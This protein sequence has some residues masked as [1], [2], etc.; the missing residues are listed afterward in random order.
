MV[1]PILVGDA[2]RPPAAFIAEEL[3]LKPARCA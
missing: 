1:Q 3:P 2:M